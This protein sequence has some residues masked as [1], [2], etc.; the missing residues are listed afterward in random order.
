MTEAGLIATTTVA[1]GAGVPAGERTSS[2]ACPETPSLTALTT[3]LPGATAAITP[4]SVTVATAGLDVCQAMGWFAKVAPLASLTVAAA[5][6]VIPACKDRGTLT[7]T[8]AATA[9]AWLLSTTA[10]P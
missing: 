9:G 4:E 10:V 7:T 8:E 2:V 5:R 3:A 6:A 1:T